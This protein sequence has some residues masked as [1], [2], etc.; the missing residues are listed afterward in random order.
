[1]EGQRQLYQPFD[2]P[3]DELQQLNYVT[4][5]EKLRHIMITEKARFKE[6]IKKVGVYV[7]PG[8]E[9][10]LEISLMTGTNFLCVG[11]LA[12]GK[13][14]LFYEVIRNMMPPDYMMANC[15][16]GCHPAK[17]IC[18]PCETEREQVLQGEKESVKVKLM[19]GPAYST[20][21][22]ARTGYN[23]DTLFGVHKYDESGMFDFKKFTPGELTVAY[24]IFG[25]DDFTQFLGLEEFVHFLEKKLPITKKAGR[26]PQDIPIDVWVYM[27]ANPTKKFHKLVEANHPFFSRV[28]MGS[29]QY[30]DEI[31]AQLAI[32]S[33]SV[34]YRYGNN[35]YNSVD[36]LREP[37]L[38]DSNVVIDS[39]DFN[40]KFI[41]ACG[42]TLREVFDFEKIFTYDSRRI[43]SVLQFYEIM[44]RRRVQMEPTDLA[45]LI[46][47]QVFQRFR[48]TEYAEK[49]P[50]LILH[51]I[52]DACRKIYCEHY[53]QSGRLKGFNSGKLKKFLNE[54][55]KD[56]QFVDTDNLSKMLFSENIN[57]EDNERGISKKSIHEPML[58]KLRI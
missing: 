45:R 51:S 56:H 22:G 44:K 39:N 43:T 53:N 52:N 49:I 7:D 10:V 12:T 19:P 40:N 15:K 38:P 41:T 48:Y 58:P 4:I 29:A 25:I 54:V 13:S 8:L 42:M 37:A 1:M 24:G 5:G 14:D 17:P 50:K 28:E 34:A 55:D 3:M 20:W 27:T 11:P 46:A 18:E 26:L 21:I 2:M 33:N 23:E 6:Q 31:D 36:P 9:Q 57:L 16:F 35:D 32:L 47:T 30:P